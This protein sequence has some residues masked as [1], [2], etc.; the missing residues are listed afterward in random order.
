M[1]WCNGEANVC[2]GIPG[3]ILESYDSQG[4]RMAKVQFGGIVREACLQYVPEA[5]AGDYVVV[6]VGFAI[7]KVNEEEAARTYK[8]L[9][10][11]GQLTEL[12]S[13]DVDEKSGNGRSP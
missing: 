13:P 4:L 6:H 8:L 1:P 12:S 3:K 9:E 5:E 2:L 7:S 10:E 11:M